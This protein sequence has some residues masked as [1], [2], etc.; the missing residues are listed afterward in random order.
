MPTKRKRPLTNAEKQACWR[1]A[2]VGTDK[3][4]VQLILSVPTAK[5]LR[6]LAKAA[7]KSI[8]A[9]VEHL[10]SLIVRPT[11]SAK[12]KSLVDNGNLADD[13]GPH[14]R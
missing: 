9:F 7:D 4:R 14:H 13:L 10:V 5:R 12:A 6:R 2:H 1:E 8:A 3:T 11:R